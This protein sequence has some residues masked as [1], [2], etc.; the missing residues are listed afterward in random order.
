MGFI[1]Y[2]VITI[3][4]DSTYDHDL[5]AENYYKDELE[6]QQRI[7]KLNNAKKLTQNITIRKVANGIFV[8]FP[9]NISQ[10]K[11]R[12]TIYLYRPSN[13]I[14]DVTLPITLSKHTQFISKDILIGGRWN[15]QVNW[16]VSDKEYLFQHKL[17]I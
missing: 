3:S 13:K 9:K 5:V 1:L 2:F 15:V 7:D 12:G 8:D 17:N 6:F 4:T 10:E 16:N 14:L 11:I